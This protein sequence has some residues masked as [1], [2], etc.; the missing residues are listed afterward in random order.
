MLT[1]ANAILTTERDCFVVNVREDM[2]LLCIPSTLTVLIVNA[3]LLLW[4]LPA[5]CCYNFLHHN[6]SFP[7]QF[8]DRSNTWV[9]DGL[10]VCH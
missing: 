10:S 7:L 1:A 8:D 5:I 6:V 9:C 3:C 4:P 2:A